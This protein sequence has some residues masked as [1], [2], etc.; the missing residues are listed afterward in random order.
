MHARGQG[1]A[2]FSSDCPCAPTQCVSS[3]FRRLFRP[4]RRSSVHSSRRCGKAVAGCS[5]AS[6]ATF[7]HPAGISSERGSVSVSS[8]SCLAVYK[9]PR[10]FASA[11]AHTPLLCSLSAVILNFIASPAWRGKDFTLP[12]FLQ[13]CLN[14]R[15]FLFALFGPSFFVI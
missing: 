11:H 2:Y 8:P 3:C 5:A 13:R 10:V 7:G 14:D 1:K 4:S 15:F 12:T 9:S 6:V